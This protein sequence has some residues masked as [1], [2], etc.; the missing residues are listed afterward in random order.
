MPQGF[1]AHQGHFFNI[2]GGMG[3]GFFRIELNGAYTRGR[4]VADARPGSPQPANVDVG[5]G[6]NRS[7]FLEIMRAG[8]A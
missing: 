2:I 8:L 3:Q 5:V 4:T 1:I 6:F 7:R